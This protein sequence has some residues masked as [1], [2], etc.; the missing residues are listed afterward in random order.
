MQS[1]TM[2]LAAMG[3]ACNHKWHSAKQQQ[4][5]RNTATLPTSAALVIERVKMCNSAGVVQLQQ[6]GSSEE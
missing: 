2:P 6:N 5:S 4:A 1:N 3:I